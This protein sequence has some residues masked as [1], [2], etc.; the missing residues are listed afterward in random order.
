MTALKLRTRSLSCP[1][2]RLRSPDW[3]SRLRAAATTPTRTACPPPRLGAI[4]G[5]RLSDP[6]TRAYRAE[7]RRLRRAIRR[8]LVGRIVLSPAA[9][10]DRQWMWSVDHRDRSPT[11]GYEAT[12]EAAMV[13]FAKSWKR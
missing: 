1:K 10:S 6:Q 12:R 8:R 4:D 5:Q 9:S 11:R 3:W 13:A 2:G 7:R